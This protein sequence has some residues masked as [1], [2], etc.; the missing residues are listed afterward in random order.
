M[1]SQTHAP[2][3]AHSGYRTDIDGLRGIGVLSIIRY[4]DPDK[5][6]GLSMN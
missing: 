4:V 1:N 2:S 6:A 3:A 5:S